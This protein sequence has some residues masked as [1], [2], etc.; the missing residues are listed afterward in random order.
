MWRFVPLILRVSM[1]A[2]ILPHIEPSFHDWI[3]VTSE[4]VSLIATLPVEQQ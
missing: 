3:S 2:E 4:I 1:Y